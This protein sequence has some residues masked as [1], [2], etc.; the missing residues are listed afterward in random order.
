M[1]RAH[2]T[3]GAWGGE[4]KGLRRQVPLLKLAFL[5]SGVEMAVGDRSLATSPRLSQG[6]L[7]LEPVRS[8]EP[9]ALPMEPSAHLASQKLQRV[10]ERSSQLLTS[11]ASLSQH[12]RSLKPIRKPEYEV[13]PFGTRDQGATKAETDLEAGLEEAEVVSANSHTGS[14]VDGDGRFTGGCWGSP[15]VLPGAL[16][17]WGI[18]VPNDGLFHSSWPHPMPSCVEVGGYEVCLHPDWLGSGRPVGCMILLSLPVLL[19]SD[20]CQ[21]WESV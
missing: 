19:P 12:H 7:D 4:L 13:P 6:S 15:F 1:E 10:L 2:W 16:L 21:G 3:P 8:P 5:D 17:W 20:G 18:S 11:P 9:L 14:R